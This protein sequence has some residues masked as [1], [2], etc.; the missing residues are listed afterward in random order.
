MKVI[1]RRIE[2]VLMSFILFSNMAYPVFATELFYAS[3]DTGLDADH[4]NGSKKAR[5]IGKAKI[6]KDGKAHISKTDK[7]SQA[8]DAGYSTNEIAAVAYST[9]GNINPLQGTIEMWIKTNYDWN[10]KDSLRFGKEQSVFFWVPFTGRG[11]K[12]IDVTCHHYTTKWPD[13]G[14]TYV[15]YL[16]FDG[17]AHY[18]HYFNVYSTTGGYRGGK[19]WTKDNWHHIAVTWTATETRLFVDRKL[20]VEKKWVKPID[21]MPFK[22]EFWLG[23][24]T[25]KKGCRAMIDEVRIYDE[26]L[27]IKEQDEKK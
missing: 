13:V 16:I 20:K 9:K 4:A 23:G 19:K 22:D 11:S 1:G 10:F 25:D 7:K 14:H 24:M 2:S 26:A 6:C 18:Q 3:F 5:I 8:L 12:R 21:L 27:L 15:G 17:L